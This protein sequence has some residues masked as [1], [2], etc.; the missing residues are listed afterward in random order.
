MYKVI[1][2]DLDGTLTESGEGITKSVQYALEKL[3]QPEPDLKKLEVFVGPPLLQQFMKYAG[4][5]EETAVKAV[6]YYRE[7]YTDIGIF[8]NEVY[9]GVEDMLDKLRGKGYILAVAS[10]KPERFVKKVLDHFD[11]TKY[12]QE[13][14]G[15]EMNGGRTSKADV[16][17]EALDRLHMAD[18]REQVVMVGDKEHDVFG[19]RKAGLKCLA[20]SYGYGSEEELKNANPLKIVDSAQEVLD[21][22]S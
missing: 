2:F 19:A 15:S 22:F 12:F 10:S 16:I 18:H 7:R 13:I 20:V 1:L 8:E 11:L 5:D 21:F 17:E 14:V 4:L 3:G 6:E 9:P